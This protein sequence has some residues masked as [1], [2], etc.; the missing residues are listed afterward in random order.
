MARLSRS[1]P[2]GRKQASRAA[3]AAG[4]LP[5]NSVLPEITGTVTVG[6]TLTCSTGT[7]SNTPTYVY[8]W[9]RNGVPIDGAAES[10]RLLAAGDLGA[11]MSC[12]VVAT[13]LR[14]QAVAT[15]AQTVAVT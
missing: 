7:W 14:V 12:T 1:T 2:A 5:V 3:D 9:R 4:K 11:L 8:Q 15:S 6:Q 10:T 13:R